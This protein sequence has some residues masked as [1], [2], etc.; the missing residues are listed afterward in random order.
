MSNL[1]IDANTD[2]LFGNF[3]MIT[4][5]SNKSYLEA[6]LYT[7]TQSD[8]SVTDGR[9]AKAFHKTTVTYPRCT[10]SWTISP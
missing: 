3:A 4:N 8:R 1:E 7:P 6:A 5:R 2:Y 9:S 10:F